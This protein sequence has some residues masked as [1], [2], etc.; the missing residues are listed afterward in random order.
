MSRP[1]VINNNNNNTF[2]IIFQF[3]TCISCWLMLYRLNMCKKVGDEI[4]SRSLLFL[5]F[6][7]N[8]EHVDYTYGCVLLI[9]VAVRSMG[10][11]A[12][13]LG[14]RV[15]VPAFVRHA[16]IHKPKFGRG[17]GGNAPSSNFS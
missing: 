9:P 4:Y 16:Q 13:L 11:V 5:I 7:N 1:T 2:I 15:H 10:Q 14:S 6:L 12:R 17:K 8:H 3:I